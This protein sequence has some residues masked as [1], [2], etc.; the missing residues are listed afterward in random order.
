MA[1]LVVDDQFDNADLVKYLLESAGYA[2]VVT[3]SSAERAFEYLG[4]DA[5]VDLILMDVNMPCVDGITACRRIKADPALEDV[6]VIMVTAQTEREVIDLAFA[7]GAAD[8]VRQPFDR[9]E[10][11]ARVRSALAL[12]AQIDCRKARERE[13]ANANLQLERLA[14]VDALTGIANRRALDEALGA[15][16]RRAAR[17]SNCLTLVLVDIDFFKAYNDTYGH[18][19]GDACL[20]RVARLLESVLRRPADLAGR[21]GGEEFV[22][23]L[24]D[25]SL[26]G[27]F[28]VAERVRAGVEAF[29]IVHTASSVASVVTISAG[30]ASATPAAG[31]LPPSLV[32]AADTALYE[33]KAAGRNRVV[34]APKSG[35]AIAGSERAPHAHGAASDASR[36]DV[37][38]R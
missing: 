22:I 7:A 10:L 11:L 37:P 5:A 6:P 30:V 36:G 28:A 8:F 38:G 20:A 29:G 19:A 26:E 21:F 23:L 12:K 31:I 33:A 27:A 17:A 35:V 4:K 18:P 15:E 34:R 16:W 2:D 14:R 3:F 32:E 13:L 1:I 24:P 25:T 9:I